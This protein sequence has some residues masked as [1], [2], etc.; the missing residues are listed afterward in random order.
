MQSDNISVVFSYLCARMESNSKSIKRHLAEWL[1]VAVPMMIYGATYRILRFVPRYMPID[2]DGLYNAEV[3][4]FGIDGHTLCEYFDVHNA[5]WADLL[6]G[7]FY[8]CWVPLPLLFAFW[9]YFTR[10]RLCLHF[11]FSFMMMNLIGFVIYYIHPA[12]PPWY[13]MRHGFEA[14]PSTQ[15]YAAGLL[16]FDSLTGCHLFED[17]YRGTTNVFAALPSLHSAKV[18]YAMLFAIIIYIKERAR[19]A[20]AWSIVLTIV[21]VGTWLTAIY[22]AHHYVID[23]LCGI[24]L[25]PASYLIFKHAVLPSRWFK[26]LEGHIQAT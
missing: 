2:T 3:S 24:A 22:T 4:V 18:P 1:L 23:V 11:T 9:L 12:A 16:R 8:I 10:R 25:V 6:A 5:P 15:G 20:L 13:V 26:R 17:M 14:I 19:S 21:S 7:I